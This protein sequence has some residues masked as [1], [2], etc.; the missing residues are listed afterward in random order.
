MCDVGGYVGPPVWEG[1]LKARGSQDFF[2]L[3]VLWVY[4]SVGM[5]FAVTYLQVEDDR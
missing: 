4:A 5:S 3:R 1:L 2:F